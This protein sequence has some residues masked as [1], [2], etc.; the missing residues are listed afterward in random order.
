MPKVDVIIKINGHS[1]RN[2]A[3]LDKKVSFS[4]DVCEEDDI[5]LRFAQ[6]LLALPADCTIKATFEVEDNEI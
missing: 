3:S 1:V 6:Y 5:K 2:L 4:C